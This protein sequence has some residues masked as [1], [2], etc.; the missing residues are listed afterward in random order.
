MLSNSKWESIAGK[1]KAGDSG[2]SSIRGTKPVK[3]GHKSGNE[4][5]KYQKKEW[6]FDIKKVKCDNC[7]KEGH[8]KKDGKNTRKKN[9]LLLRRPRGCLADG[10]GV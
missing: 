1:K 3:T 8:F 2:P 5:H 10:T 4:S 7:G 9:I 6:K